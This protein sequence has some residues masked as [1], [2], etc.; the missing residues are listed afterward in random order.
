MGCSTSSVSNVQLAHSDTRI[1][2]PRQVT[3]RTADLVQDQDDALDETTSMADSEHD[4]SDGHK[5][6][7]Y[8]LGP[9]KRT[10]DA[11]AGEMIHFMRT[12]KFHPRFL[13]LAVERK[14]QISQRRG[15]GSFG[16]VDAP[17]SESSLGESARSSAPLA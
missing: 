17:A 9:N 10:H 5:S 16:D 6:S 11:H 2:M 12:I 4:E 7:E 15:L 14:K 1:P 13:E 3:A 8:P